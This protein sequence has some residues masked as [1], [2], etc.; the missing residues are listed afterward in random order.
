MNQIPHRLLFAVLLSA[1]NGVLAADLLETFHAAQANDPVFAS[2]RAT[3]QAGQEKLPQGRSA[4]LPSV[5]LS[6]NTTYND[7]TI[8]YS[9]ATFLPGG[10]NRYNSHGYG[11]SLV[12]PLFRQ[13]NWMAYSESEL[14]VT[15]AEAQFRIAE[16]DLMLRVAQAYFDVLIAQDSV[17]LVEAQKT[18]IAEQLEQAKRNFEV[19]SSTITDTLEAQARHDLTGAQEIAA[20]NNLE[21]KRSALQQLINAVPK[22]LKPLGKDFRLEAPQPADMEKWVDNAQANS[23]QLA[24]AQAGATIADKE[25][26][27][28]RGGHYPTVDIVANFSKNVANG[29]SFGVGSDNTNKSIGMQLNLPLFQGG[30]V[31]SRLREAQANRERASQ[32]LENARRN[33]AQQTRQ[34]YLG[35][36]SGIAQVKALQ[37]ALA[38]GES[39]LEA[40][41]LGHEV[42]VRT[43]LDVLNAQQQLF[44]TRR[45]LFQAQYNFLISQLRLKAAV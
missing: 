23:L 38:S 28:N 34:A 22:D 4:L 27:R 36:V 35:V 16:Q 43:N 8:Q 24:I 21:I 19:G 20:R 15:Q 45:D 12:Q 26:E 25:V 30:G 9:S 1:S 7:S 2:A 42:G 32:E 17:Q 6:A 39:V 40:S 33:V 41:K 3:L 29:G 11:V 5:N 31:N 14:Q 37:Q 44:S 13:Q 10:T 18:A